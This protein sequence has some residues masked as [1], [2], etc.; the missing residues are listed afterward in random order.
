M[1]NKRT[2]TAVIAG[3]VLM[4]GAGVGAGLVSGG[5]PGNQGTLVGSGGG[6]V[7]PT[8]NPTVKLCTSTNWT[9]PTGVCPATKGG[10]GLFPASGQS[11][12]YYSTVSPAGGSTAPTGTTA[13]Y[14]APTFQVNNVTTTAGSASITISSGSFNGIPVG[15]FVQ[16]SGMDNNTVVSSVDSSTSITL[17]NVALSSGTPNLTFIEGGPNVSGSTAECSTSSYTYSGTKATAFC[18]TLSRASDAN[19]L[20][21]YAFFSPDSTAQAAG[22]G[23]AQTALWVTRTT[24]QTYVSQLNQY[25]YNSSQTFQQNFVSNASKLVSHNPGSTVAAPTPSKQPSFP[26]TGGA[27][28]GAPP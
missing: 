7:A 8:L 26:T 2:L 14:P 13:F 18:T 10:G 16:G 17:S 15:S 1:L 11:A 3:V 6:L 24:V 12:Y 4:V 9:N 23:Y 28:P 5:T 25:S 20:N 19:E 21:M 27:T 22:I